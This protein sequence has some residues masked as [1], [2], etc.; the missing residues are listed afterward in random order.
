[1]PSIPPL[2]SLRARMG[3]KRPGGAVIISSYV[4]DWIVVVVVFG[5]A[6]YMN[7]HEP[8]RRPFSLEDPNI[9]FPFTEHETVPS[10]LLITLCTGVPIVVIPIISLLFV[11]GHTVPS[12]TPKA[13]IWR[14]KLWEL[15]VGWLGL[16]L[17]LAGTW[18][19]TNGMKNMCGKPRP[20]LLARCNPDVDNF[21]QY[22][23]G[24]VNVDTGFQQLVSAD[25]CRGMANHDDAQSILEDGFRSYPSGH[26]SSSAA[27]LVYLSLFIASK[28]AITIPFLAPGDT[29]ATS[30]TA[31]PSRSNL[32]SRQEDQQRLSAPHNPNAQHLF[33]AH[34]ARL[35][36]AR[37]QAAA[38]PLYLLVLAVVPFFTAVFIASSRWFNFRHHGFDILFGFFIGTVCA[39]FAFRWYHL[40]VS[41]GAGWAWGPRSADKAFWAGVGSLSYA[42]EWEQ[43]VE[44][45]FRQQQQRELPDEE[46]PHD[47]AMMMEEGRKGVRAGS[48]DSTGLHGD[49][50]DQDARRTMS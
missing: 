41:R 31:F 15:H 5:I 50:E 20:D 28:F 23:L 43:D 38:P 9:S 26:S 21:A 35:T 11:P 29:S 19:I 10:W 17:S 27:G 39:F 18:F 48:A 37:R 44:D 3:S 36:A 42:T 34:N 32:S 40:P 30:F 49:I 46:R 22:V 4:F 16:A 24:G 25:I 14:R 47:A 8:N 13:L 33:S 1:M 6:A 7:N 2:Q 45:G 12:S